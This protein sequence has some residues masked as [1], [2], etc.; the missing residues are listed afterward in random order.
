MCTVTNGANIAFFKEFN[1]ISI[2]A[3]R[4][5]QVYVIIIDIRET[6]RQVKEEQSQSNSFQKMAAA[7][8]AMTSEEDNNALR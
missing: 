7:I 3:P 8:W 5:K 1:M 2:S 4:L 6:M